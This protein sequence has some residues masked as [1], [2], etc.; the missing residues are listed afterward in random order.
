MEW[1]PWAISVDKQDLASSRQELVRRV[2]GLV[3]KVDGDGQKVRVSWTNSS[4][5]GRNSCAAIIGHCFSDG[6]PISNRRSGRIPNTM[7]LSRH[8]FLKDSIASARP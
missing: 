4:G 1:S 7:R 8:Q 6:W 3:R 5:S 2:F